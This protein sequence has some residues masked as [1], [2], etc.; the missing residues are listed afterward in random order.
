[1]KLGSAAAVALGMM[2]SNHTKA[3]SLEE[4]FRD[5]ESV[6]LVGLGHNRVLGL[7]V[8]FRHGA[9]LSQCLRRTG[10]LRERAI[11]EGR[12]RELSESQRSARRVSGAVICLNAG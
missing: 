3:H 7:D 5:V 1:M 10:K 6:D 8:A 4:R 2:S 9:A 12:G 11:D